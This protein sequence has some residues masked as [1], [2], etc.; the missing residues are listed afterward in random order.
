ME[1]LTTFTSLVFLTKRRS[2]LIGVGIVSVRKAD[3]L[4]PFFV[5]GGQ[6]FA[7]AKHADD[8]RAIVAG[9][10]EASSIACCLILAVNVYRCV[11]LDDSSQSL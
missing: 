8:V 6:I 9:M 7:I 10:A 5:V 4:L 3:K 11:L 2:G 1:C